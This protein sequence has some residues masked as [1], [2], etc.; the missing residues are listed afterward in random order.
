VPHDI[1]ATSNAPVTASVASPAGTPT[2]AAAVAVK[3][4][5]VNETD[6]QMSPAPLANYGHEPSERWPYELPTDMGEHSGSTM[7]ING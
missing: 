1:P 7:T 2:S 5:A 3:P 4:E 6:S